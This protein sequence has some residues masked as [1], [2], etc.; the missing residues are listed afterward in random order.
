MTKQGDR[1]AMQT[2]F[3]N[4]YKTVYHFALS[5]VK[6]PQYAEVFTQEVYITTFQEISDICDSDSFFKLLNNTT[7]KY[8]KEILH[9]FKGLSQLED[10]ERIL[11]TIDYSPSN[12]PDKA[13]DSDETRKIIFSVVDKLPNNQRLCTMLHYYAKFSTKMISDMLE[14]DENATK[15]HLAIA[16]SKIRASVYDKE[17]HVGNILSGTPISIT[18]ILRGYIERF[19]VSG[20][21]EQSM[22]NNINGK[23]KLNTLA[24]ND[25]F[26][27]T[28]NNFVKEPLS[29]TSVDTSKISSGSYGYDDRQMQ[30]TAD[31]FKPSNVNRRNTSSKNSLL[32]KRNIGIAAAVLVFAIICIIVF[33]RLTGSSSRPTQDDF[34]KVL[35]E[36][37][38]LR[39]RLENAGL[40]PPSEIQPYVPAQP[41]SN[42]SANPPA[43]SENLTLYRD[44]LSAPPPYFSMLNDN[45]VEWSV[46]D[47]VYAELVDF[48]NSGTQELILMV[49]PPFSQ[50]NDT[51]PDDKEFGFFTLGIYN[52]QVVEYWGYLISDRMNTYISYS[53]ASDA[54]GK[55]FLK[56]STGT[57][58]DG[59]GQEHVF[60]ELKNG[61]LTQVL[62]ITSDTGSFSMSGNDEFSINGNSVSE[63][64]YN[65]AASTRLGIIQTTD[66]NTSTTNNVQETLS[67]LGF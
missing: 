21:S 66:I 53:L 64:E 17:Q 30:S 35:A 58:S 56:Y 5:L 20:E 45:L 3:L 10:D 28:D 39:R 24:H 33:P 62:S 19:I 48:D 9:K 63:S 50:T 65:N 25:P 12:L 47:I 40:T 52:S 27:I 31:S 8:C 57:Y 4:S 23:A 34:D 16:R 7:V 49:N 37:I 22:W 59:A 43:A 18:S 60:F 55:V 41:Q 36:N 42:D 54:S 44:Y 46:Q 6:N 51:D 13:I 32:K 61:E 38:E 1:S 26:G 15:I 11:D 2:L 67:K 14:A 29:T